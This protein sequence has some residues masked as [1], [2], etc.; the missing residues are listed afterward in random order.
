AGGRKPTT[1]A[2]DVRSGMFSNEKPNVV[3]LQIGYNGDATQEHFTALLN[4]LRAAFPDAK[5]VF[6]SLPPPAGAQARA[7]TEKSKSELKS[8]A[9]DR[10]VYY[11]DLEPI[12]RDSATGEPRPERLVGIGVSNEGYELWCDAMKPLLERLPSLASPAGK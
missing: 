10:T 2:D 6:T 8:L 4:A 11:V 1:L 12:F 3:V 9:D 5:F 7:A